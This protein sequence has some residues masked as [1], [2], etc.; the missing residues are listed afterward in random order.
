M[1]FAHIS[2]GGGIVGVET[3]ISTFD[4]IC[5]SLK[6][7]NIRQNFKGKKFSFAI[8]DTKPE[9]IP[10]GVAY[11]FKTSQYGYFNN[12]L[13]LSPDHLKRWI[14]L[15]NN[16]KKIV[17][18]IKKYGGF[19][20]KIWLRDNLHILNSENKKKFME[21]YF[22]RVLANFWMEEKLLLLLK[23][24]KKISKEFSILFEIKFIKGNVI[25]IRNNTQKYSEISFKDN[26]YE[27]LELE[28]NKNHLKK[29]N[30]KNI[31]TLKSGSIYSITQCVSLGLPPPK[32][33]ATNRSRS[34]ANYIRDFYYSGATSNL[35]NKMLSIVKKRG[36][37]KIIIYFI[38]YKAGLLEPLPELKNIIK[39][40]KISTEIICSS[41]DLLGIQKA[42]GSLNKKVYKLNKLNIKKLAR[43]KSAKKLFSSI[44]AEFEIAKNHGYKKYDAWTQILNKAILNKCIKNFNNT[45]KNLYKNIIVHKIRAIT[46]FTY[47]ATIEARDEL[48]S[49]GILKTKK[50]TVKNVDKFKNKLLVLVNDIYKVPKKYFC[51]LVVNVSGP[52]S[53]LKLKNEWPVIDSIKKNNG[54]IIDGGFIVSDNF[55][56]TNNKNIY[57]PGY[58][59][60]GFNPARKT[61]I[62]AILENSHKTGQSIAK[63][64]YNI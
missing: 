49:S 29:I 64:L 36:K 40:Y 28:I 35:I 47:P 1:Y 58:L 27:I 13:R 11:G 24:M 10:G 59:A 44:L 16:K 33:L 25:S 54:K 20:G 53:A 42:Q 43:I 7:K 45:E 31:S 61:I 50:E 52:L 30:F 6:K 2:I 5:S 57:I 23:K 48:I 18:Y 55:E 38:G 4:N 34:H 39:K 8:V 12:P 3:V 17:H 62:K 60:N 15:R 19:T 32:E 63:T 22:P 14:S 41:S 56:L 51:D 26:K 37:K 21:I 9:N 46:R